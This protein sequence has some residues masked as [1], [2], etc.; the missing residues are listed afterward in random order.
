MPYTTFMTRGGYWQAAKRITESLERLG[1]PVSFDD[2]T[3]D[4]MLN[5]CQPQEYRKYEGQ[6]TIGYTPWESTGMSGPCFAQRPPESLLGL[7]F[8]YQD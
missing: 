6:Y 4:V 5:F 7:G 8:G 2:P 1:V 3:A